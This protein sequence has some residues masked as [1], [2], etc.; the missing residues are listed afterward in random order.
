M[1]AQPLHCSGTCVIVCLRVACAGLL[2]LG[3]CMAVLG[4]AGS[5][6]GP[7]CDCISSVLQCPFRACLSLRRAVRVLLFTGGSC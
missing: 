3:H 4:I 7:V 6:A 1:N 2:L 5:W